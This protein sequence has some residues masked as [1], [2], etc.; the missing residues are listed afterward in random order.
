MKQLTRLTTTGTS[1]HVD[2]QYFYSATQ[3]NGKITGMTDWVTG[4]DVTYTYDSLERLASAVTTTN[5]NVPRKWGQ[6]YGYD[7]FGNL[8]DQTLTKGSGPDVHHA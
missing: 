7:G 6:S 5:P 1:D 3:N 4:E 2:F 8:T